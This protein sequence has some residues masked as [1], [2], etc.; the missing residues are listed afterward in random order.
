MATRKTSESTYV[1]LDI[2]DNTLD[3][4]AKFH[5]SDEQ[6]HSKLDTPC[7]GLGAIDRHPLEIIC[8]TLLLLDIQSLTDFRRVNKRSKL[9]TD[10]HPQY[11]LIRVHA[12]L[13]VLGSLNIGTARFFSCG[14]FYDRITAA[15]C[16]SCGDFGG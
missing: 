9:I 3:D 12:P 8:M 15:E 6:R 4:Y 1:F 10:S 13:S 11:K 16:E 5:A 7:Y 2:Q 14:D